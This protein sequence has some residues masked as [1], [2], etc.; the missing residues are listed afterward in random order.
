MPEFEK[1][2]LSLEP[3]QLFHEPVETSHGFHLIRLD[4]RAPGECVPFSS[5]QDRIMIYLR[6]AAWRLALRAFISELAEKAAIEGFTLDPGRAVGQTDP[7][8]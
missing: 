6:D 8:H 4:D 5:V 3:G 7:I 2:L 1:A